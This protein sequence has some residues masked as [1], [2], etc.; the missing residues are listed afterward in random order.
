MAVR[1]GLHALGKRYRV[2]AALPGLPRRR[3]DLLFP[4][5]RLAVFIDGC[6]WH[7]CPLHA[8]RPKA[9]GQWWANKLAVNVDRDRNTDLHLAAI[10]WKVLRF[11]EHE[12][13]AAV[14]AKIIASLPPSKLMSGTEA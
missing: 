9:N 5:A 1:R 12:P 11:W 4:K 2:H 14:V 3:A 13:P 7:S 10:G 8:T 6:F